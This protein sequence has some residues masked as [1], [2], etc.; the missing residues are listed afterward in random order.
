[1]FDGE[2]LELETPDLRQILTPCR[3]CRTITA[4]VYEIIKIWLDIQ[5]PHFDVLEAAQHRWK[6]GRLLSNPF[7]V[8]CRMRTMA[9]ATSEHSHIS[10]ESIVPAL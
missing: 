3:I 8:M 9:G 4:H 6:N 2:P 7:E 10:E 1:M 5:T